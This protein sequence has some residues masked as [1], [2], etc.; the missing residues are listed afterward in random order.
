MRKDIEAA[1]NQKALVFDP[2]NQIFEARKYSINRERAEEL[3]AVDSL[4]ALKKKSCKK[5]IY[6]EKKKKIEKSFKL[7]TTKMLIKFNYLD[8]ATMLKKSRLHFYPKK[9]LMFAKLSLMRF[10]YDL[11]E[12]FTFTD[13]TNK[14][15]YKK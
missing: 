10:I 9:I 2:N 6:I 4:V 3:D 14:E 8:S 12:T 15:I 5:H 13:E 11:V 1:F 7:K